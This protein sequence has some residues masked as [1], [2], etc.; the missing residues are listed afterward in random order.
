MPISYQEILIAQGE[1]I[2]A[3]QALAAS[4]LEAARLSG[5]AYGTNDAA[6]RILRLDA[7]RAALNARASQFVVSQQVPADNKYRLSQDERDV[8]RSA[9]TDLPVEERDRIYA[10][11]KARYQHARATGAYRDDTGTV[12]R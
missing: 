12:R 11:N 4:D 5:D 9:N 7:E 2:D 1:R 8:A 6:D 3:E 10:Q